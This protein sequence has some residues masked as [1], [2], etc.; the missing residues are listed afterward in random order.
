[1]KL[2]VLALFLLLTPNQAQLDTLRAEGYEALF[3]LDYETAHKRFQQMMVWAP[4]DPAGPECYAMS[5]WVQQ[6]NEQW[7]LKSTLYSDNANDAKTHV[8]RK[9]SEEFRRWTRQAKQLAQARLRKNPKDV[10]ALYFLGAA[11]GLESAF[12]AGVERKF[13]PAF[14]SGQDAVEHHRAVLKLAPDFHDAEL[15][16]GLMNYVIGSLPLPAK[17]LAATMGV[18]GS[19]K[20]GL[21]AL[22]RVANEGKWAHDIA[23]MLLIDLYRREKRFDDAAKTANEL[24]AKY[25]RNYL[26][27]QL[28]HR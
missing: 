25:P 22:E 17:M 24:A 5:L 6:L 8:D 9:Q 16:I 1:M 10:E 4:D 7:K 21:E 13:M 27:K 26:F 2:A 18:H 20:R 19:K 15:T 23:R 12:A 28:S 11:E 3:N 14:R